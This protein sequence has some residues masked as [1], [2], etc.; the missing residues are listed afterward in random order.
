MNKQ[1]TELQAS[2]VQLIYRSRIPTANRVQIK[3]SYDA[4]KVFWEHWDKD[5]IEHIEEFKMLLL[6]NKNTV[7]GIATISKG[8]ST[9][10]VIDPRIIS[11][12]GL[13]AHASAVIFGHNHPS[14]NPTPSEADVSITK[15]LQDAGNVLEIRVLDHIILCSDQSYYSLMD[16]CR[17]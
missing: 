11:Q 6:N 13:K 1:Q 2:E 5:T 15:R 14:N 10:T 16:E 8:G 12:Y 9:G 4:F 17:M 3:T 7:L